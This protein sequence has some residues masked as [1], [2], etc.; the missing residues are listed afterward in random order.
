M[1]APGVGDVTFTRRQVLRTGAA[2]LAGAAVAGCTSSCPDRG[3]PTPAVVVRPTDEPTA[4]VAPSAA[5]PSLR[6]DP[7]NTGFSPAA[8]IP[9]RPALAWR[10]DV[11]ATPTP[12]SPP[13]LAGSVY[14]VDGGGTLRAL[15]PSDGTERWSVDVGPEAHHVVGPPTVAGDLLVVAGSDGVHAV[16]VARRAVRWRRSDLAATAPAT[17]AADRVFVPTEGELLALSA[18]TGEE[19]WSTPLDG[20]VSRPAVARG[21]V[22]ATGAEVAAHGVGDG[23]EL[24]RGGPAFADDP[25]VVADGRVYVGSVDGLAAYGLATG[26]RLWRFERGSGRGFG[27]PVVTPDTLY[28]VELVGEGP[29]A[30]FALDPDTGEPS[31]R[32]CSYMGE[33]TA[34]AAGPEAVLVEGPPAE[35]PAAGHAVG[36]LTRETGR[37][38]WQFRADRLVAPPAVADGA[39][40]C[41]TAG[42]AVCALGEGSP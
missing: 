39:V 29:D 21:V 38:T 4:R 40:Y 25:P 41:V 10:T 5:W 16:D 9:A 12:P 30:V 7:R 33:G 27:A 28:A 31:P 2:V 26:D 17:V 11:P 20:P 42:G 37:A 13:A 8:R 22:L 19:G 34:H 32:W 36:A 35:G 24:W 15:D 23:T 6:H 3:R 14:L 1:V 18:P